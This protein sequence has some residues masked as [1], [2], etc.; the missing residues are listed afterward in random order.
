MV[1]S[2]RSRIARE[3]ANGSSILLDSVSNFFAWNIWNCILYRW[4]KTIHSSITML[5]I[6]ILACNSLVFLCKIILYNIPTFN[7]V[8]RGLPDSERIM[9]FPARRVVRFQ[10]LC[11]LNCFCY[12]IC[13]I[14]SFSFFLVK[15]STNA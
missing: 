2:T 11:S 6:I 8:S 9:Q 7:L 12:C 15:L 10:W 13:S 4:R 3:S 1:S 5:L 14:L